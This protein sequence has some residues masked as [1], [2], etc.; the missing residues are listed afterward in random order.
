MAA[1]APNVFGLAAAPKVAPV[2][3]DVAPNPKLPAAGVVLPIPPNP[4]N[5]PEVPGFAAAP[6]FNVDGVPKPPGV[7]PAEPNP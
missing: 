2:W 7:P 4:P 3:L 1:G 6:K 5:A